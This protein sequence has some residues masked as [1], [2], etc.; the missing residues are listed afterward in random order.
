M[1]EYLLANMWQ[2]WAVLAVLGLILEL[3]S[4]DFF[5]MCL[6]IGAA[7]AAITAPFANLYW[8]IGVFAIVSLFSLFQV[9]PFVLRYLHN[10]EEK[11]VSNADALL[12][13][14]GRVSETIPAGGFGY[15]AIDG[16]QW[17]AVA[18][19]DEEIAEGTR[20]KIVSRESTIVTVEQLVD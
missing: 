1:I 20:V 2:V 8:Q 17:R 5:I 4:G 16:D 3:T 14:K 18:A 15:V 19:N 6:A 12:G 9:R 10:N 13:R 11:R 7:G